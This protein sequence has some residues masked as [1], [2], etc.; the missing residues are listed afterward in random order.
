MAAHPPQRDDR[1]TAAQETAEREAV[2]QMAQH[3]ITRVPVD[4]FHFRGFRYTNL[5]DAIAEATR[6]EQADAVRRSAG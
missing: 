6:H 4:Y 1:P 2:D 3:G 5:E